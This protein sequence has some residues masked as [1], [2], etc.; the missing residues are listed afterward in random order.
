MIKLQ[1]EWTS[2]PTSYKRTVQQFAEEKKKRPQDINPWHFITQAEYCRKW[3]GKDLLPNLTAVA[4]RTF[5]VAGAAGLT[6]ETVLVVSE[7]AEPGPDGEKVYSSCLLTFEPGA[8]G[9][10]LHIKGIHS[11][12]Q[13]V[14][15]VYYELA[16]V[17]HLTPSNVF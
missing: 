6:F 9:H 11:I 4:D 13:E 10:I 1:R 7:S 2:N 15:I 14:G 12:P 16:K 17:M 8:T 5:F 3:K